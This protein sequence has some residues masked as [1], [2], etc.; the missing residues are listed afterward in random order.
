MSALP[1]IDTLYEVCART[2]PAVREQRLGPWIIRDGGGGGQRVSATTAVDAFDPSDLAQ[3]EVAMCALGQSSLFMVR[4]GEVELDAMLAANGYAIKDPVNFYACPVA[5]LTDLEI[6]R[7]TAF[8]M[9][10]PLQIMRD[11]WASGGIDA[12]RVAVMERSACTKTGLLGRWNDHPSG[13]GYVAIHN[14]VA[15]VHALEIL[16]HQRGM[17]VGKW[18]MRRAAVW[19]SEQGA[20]MM[21]VICTK[22]NAAANALYTSLGME[23]IGSY[24]YRI[25]LD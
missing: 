23:L 17:G 3:A 19:A 21:S 16:E 10:E 15:M 25:K 18:M 9:W 7:V 1:A 6:P 24:H 14:Q 12:A 20:Q 13:T 11:I 5:H 4:E 8:T 22:E 2:W